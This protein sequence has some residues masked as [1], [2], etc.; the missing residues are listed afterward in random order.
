MSGA[1]DSESDS[2]LEFLI[3]FTSCVSVHTMLSN[4]S[5][6][7]FMASLYSFKRI[8]VLFKKL[9]KSSVGVRVR[10]TIE[11]FGGGSAFIIGYI[12]STNL[13]SLS[14]LSAKNSFVTF[15]LPLPLIWLISTSLMLVTA[16]ADVT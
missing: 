5:W 3:F 16:R 9:S 15:T 8:P 11:K 10:G 14:T 13:V 2:E 1:A 7:A 6:F 4:F 12:L